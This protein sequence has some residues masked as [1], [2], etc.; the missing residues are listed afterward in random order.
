MN[1]ELIKHD[2]VQLFGSLT[3][4][5]RAGEAIVFTADQMDVVID[6]LFAVAANFGITFNVT[7]EDGVLNIS[8]LNL[9]D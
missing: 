4:G 8:A 6:K 5:T 2:F 3:A 1:S 9:E 7:R